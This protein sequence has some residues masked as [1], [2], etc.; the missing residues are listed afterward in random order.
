[1]YS[2]AGLAG[3]PTQAKLAEIVNSLAKRIWPYNFEPIKPVQFTRIEPRL[4]PDRSSWPKEVRDLPVDLIEQA[5]KDTDWYGQYLPQTDSIL[6]PH[7]GKRMPGKGKKQARQ[8]VAS[9]PR[10]PPVKPQKTRNNDR[11]RSNYGPIRPEPVS[12]GISSGGFPS[13]AT[14]ASDMMSVSAPTNRGV[15][16]RTG[17]PRQ[18]FMPNG[19]CIIQHREFFAD[20][21]GSVGTAV[22]GYPINPGLNTP[23]P[24]LSRI[25]A[26]YESYK[27]LDLKILYST[28]AGATSTGTVCIGIDYD[29][30][31][32]LPTTKSQLMSYRGSVRNSPWCPM[33]H[34]SIP[35]DLSKRSSYFV[36]Q[37][38]LAPADDPALY[39]VGQLIILTRGQADTAF[40]GELYLEYT[41]RLMTPQ[42]NSLG[43]GNAV[44]GTYTTPSNSQLAVYSAGNLPATVVN[45]GTTTAVATFTF[46]QGWTGFIS[47]ALAGTGVTGSAL[48][49]TGLDAATWN[50]CSNATALLNCGIGRVNAIAGSTVIL[51]VTNTTLLGDARSVIAFSQ[52]LGALPHSKKVDPSAFIGKAVPPPKS[53][54]RPTTPK[55]VRVEVSEVEDPSMIVLT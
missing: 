29:P 26:N 50:S 19:D 14:S 46:T 32:G 28:E 2:P 38:A 8:K 20:V 49:G 37:G 45:S 47:F 43:G 52:G 15:F 18:S 48:A 5:Y 11:R 41:V 55:K 53:L 24:W 16:A 51:T 35:E 17:R 54:S 6:P 34:V 10:G 1:M 25:A 27:F 36:R 13:M 7:F 21:P 9:I 23:F 44:W 33:A 39:D 42:S 30:L 4:V 22:T 12:T 40:V 3:S 31:A